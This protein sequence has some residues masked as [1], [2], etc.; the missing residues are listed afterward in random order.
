MQRPLFPIETS[1]FCLPVSAGCVCHRFRWV[2]RRFRSSFAPL[3]RLNLFCCKLAAVSRD[4]ASRVSRQ[5]TFLSPNVLGTVCSRCIF[6]PHF[7]ALLSFLV[8]KSSCLQ[9]ID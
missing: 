5:P 8:S 1:G 2:L 3:R 6:T 7:V 4:D 9:N